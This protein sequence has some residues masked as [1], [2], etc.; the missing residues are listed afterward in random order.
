[1]NCGTFRLSRALSRAWIAS[2]DGEG[3]GPDDLLIPL[4][5]ARIGSETLTVRIWN[6]LHLEVDPTIAAVSAVLIA[7]TAAVVGTSSL[8]RRGETT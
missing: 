2:A 1:M 8:L 4:F 3:T 5:L 7:I 6:S